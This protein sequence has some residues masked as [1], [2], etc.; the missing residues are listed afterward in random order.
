[1]RYLFALLCLVAAVYAAPQ[2]HPSFPKGLPIVGERF[3]PI[4]TATAAQYPWA[5]KIDADTQI[6]DLVSDDQLFDKVQEMEAYMQS[7]VSNEM[8]VIKTDPYRLNGKYLEVLKSKAIAPNDLKLICHYPGTMPALCQDIAK[9]DH[10]VKLTY[11]MV[12]LQ[13]DNTV[14]PVVFISHKAC[15]NESSCFWM[16]HPAEIAVVDKSII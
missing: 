13:G 7:R 15:P 3:G 14:F 12:K 10:I 8:A 11:S 16:S 5:L 1:M 2:Q 6:K 9:T 4:M